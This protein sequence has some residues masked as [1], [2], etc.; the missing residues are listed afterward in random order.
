[1]KFLDSNG[2]HGAMVAAAAAASSTTK[3]P[4]NVKTDCELTLKQIFCF[5]YKTVLFGINK[6]I[7]IYIG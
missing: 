3:K 7:K 5:A 2:W 6:Y 1:M 4:L